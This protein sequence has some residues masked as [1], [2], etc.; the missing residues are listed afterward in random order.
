MFRRDCAAL[1]RR[2]RR[3]YTLPMRMRWAAALLGLSLLP[4]CGPDGALGDSR[5]ERL[6]RAVKTG[7]LRDAEALLEQGADIETRHPGNGWTP[8]MWAATR[9]NAQG[10]RLLA[11]RG[12]DLEARDTRGQTALMNAARWGRLVGVDA[13]LAA[14]AKV[15]AR[16]RNGWTALMWAAFK[17]QARTAAFL[18]DRGAELESKDPDGRRPLMLAAMKGH[19]E[20]VRLLLARGAS[21]S[22]RGPSGA[23]AAE[24]ARAGGYEALARELESGR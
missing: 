24:L 16:D 23:T 17:G 7:D 3:R 10:V 14:G 8:L 4:G 5:E 12:A 15:G 11:G 22:A 20:T 18:L 21:R 9:E 2:A 19:A 6:L 13:L 1:D